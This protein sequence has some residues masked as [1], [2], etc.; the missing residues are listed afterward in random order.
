H[1]T[2]PV[3]RGGGPGFESDRAVTVLAHAELDRGQPRNRP[4]AKPFSHRRHQVF[5]LGDE[6]VA[7]LDRDELVALPAQVAEAGSARA[8]S[9]PDAVAERSRRGEDGMR[10]ADRVATDPSQAFQRVVEDA[11]LGP[12]LPLDG[13]MLELASPAVLR[14]RTD[15]RHSLRPRLEHAEDAPPFIA[16]T[17]LD[18]LHLDLIARRGQ[19]DEN[20]LSG[21]QGADA[22]ASVGDRVDAH[23]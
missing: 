18:D 21:R 11:L 14:V 12:Q 23:A 13:E 9:G 4:L 19:R 5:E 6:K 10:R 22:L 17:A 8:Q 2:G 20:P 16:W 3:G 7:G 1:P 15:R